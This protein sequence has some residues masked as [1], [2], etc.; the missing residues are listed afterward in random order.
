MAGKPDD[1][2]YQIPYLQGNDTFYDWVNYHNTLHVNKLNNIKIYNG[3]SGDG[4]VF[5]LGT[6]ASNDPVGG[7]TAGSDLVAGT[8]RCDIAETIARGVTFQGDVSIN[9]SLNYDLTSLEFPSITSRVHPVGGYT[10]ARDGFTLG[11][12]VRVDDFGHQHEGGTGTAN[13]YLARADNANWAEVF[14][15]VS[16][17]TWPSSSGTPQGPYTS[18]NTYVEVT[19]HG[20]IR[21]DW[22]DATSYSAGLSAG[23]IYFLDPGTSGG[24][25]PHEPTIAGYVNKPLI[26]GITSDTGYVLNYRGQLLTGS[27][28]GGTGGINDNR[29]IVAHGE[30]EGTFERGHVVGFK[31]DRGWFVAT[32][33]DENLDHAVGLVLDEFILDGTRYMTVL[34]TGFCGDLPTANTWSKG[35]LYVNSSGKLENE[36][37]EDGVP[38]TIGNPRKPFAIGWGSGGDG[39]GIIKGTII[40]QNH[41]GGGDANAANAAGGSNRSRNQDGSNGNWAFKSNTEGGATYGSAINPNI[42]INGGFD[43]WQRG[44]GVGGHGLTGT[45][46]FADRWVRID[47]ASGSA[48][49]NSSGATTGT[50]NIERKTFATNQSEVSGNPKYY[51][52]FQN[53]FWPQGSK[54]GGH[55]VIENRIEDVRTLRNQ[56]A[57]LS[58]WARS[59]VT[60]ST[61]SIVLNQYDG[62]NTYTR[63]PSNFTLGGLWQKYEVAFKV[64]DIQTTPSGKHYLGVGFETTHMNTTFELAQVKLERGL[65]AT[66][67]DS[68]AQQIEKDLHDC[69]RYYQRSYDINQTSISKTMMEDDKTPDVTCINFTLSPAKDHHFRFP[70]EMRSEPTVTLYSPYSGQTGDGYNQ[71]AGTDL[72]HTAGT[73]GWSSDGTNSTPRVAP[74]GATTI[75]AEYITKNGIYIFVPAGSVAFDEVSVHYVADADLT[76]N[77]NNT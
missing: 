32:Q 37:D 48:A 45:T 2:L 5:T 36:F 75:S 21:G 23:C 59:G 3:L 31:T 47:G 53:D 49:Y 70:V 73:Y 1:N 56:N 51:V 29:F 52:E 33:S 43:V 54:V 15:V 19:T 67:N 28:T 11:Q 76:D 16:G 55:A 17:V 77:M 34:T 4:I 25:T 6:T 10:A 27:G 39:T 42:L 61:G 66:R 9:G 62:T 64:P 8:F 30:S 60:G 46:Y 24:I 72:R 14:G 68:S 63:K 13:Y 41:L 50:F 40:N 35:L 7:D 26:L 12:A 18:A 20:K 57:T 38:N 58:F 22:S 71:S 74:T 44:I 65:V 69:S